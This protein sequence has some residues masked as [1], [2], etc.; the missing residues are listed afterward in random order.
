MDDPVMVTVPAWK[1]RPQMAGAMLLL[2]GY[3]PPVTVCDHC[4][5]SLE[6]ADGVIDVTFSGREARYPCPH[7]G[8]LSIRALR[9][10]DRAP[11]RIP[12]TGGPGGA[13]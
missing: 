6:R 5:K 2:K 7:C 9:R 8:D 1:K 4:Q 12:W 3:V 11:V 13:E 10:P